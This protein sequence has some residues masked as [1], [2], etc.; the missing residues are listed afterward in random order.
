MVT[1]LVIKLIVDVC[2]PVCVLAVHFEQG[3]YDECIKECEEAVEIGREH[4]ADFK[5]IAKWAACC[6][7]IVHP[8]VSAHDKQTES[9]AAESNASAKRKVW[10]VD[11]S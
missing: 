4:R 2:T 6:W 1:V 9:G 7:L 5:L 3:H 8:V 10:F 11:S